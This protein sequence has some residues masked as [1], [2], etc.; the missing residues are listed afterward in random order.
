MSESEYQAKLQEEIKLILRN[1][2]S[3]YKNITIRRDYTLNIQ[4]SNVPF[5]L[6]RNSKIT[7]NSINQSSASTTIRCLTKKGRSA[8]AMNGD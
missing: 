8:F 1:N 3:F 5:I 6:I 4:L 2:I 7:N